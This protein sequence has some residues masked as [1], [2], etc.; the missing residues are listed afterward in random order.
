MFADKD[1][2]MR[3]PGQRPRG[4]GPACAEDKFVVLV[5]AREGAGEGRRR[6]GR[7]RR[8]AEAAA[9]RAPAPA[10]RS[11]ARRVLS[12][13]ARVVQRRDAAHGMSTVARRGRSAAR[14][15]LRRT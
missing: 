3:H 12:T 6:G 14:P 7:R 13:R 11:A 1:R 10:L 2:R 4:E 15:P 8:R 9:L 5:R